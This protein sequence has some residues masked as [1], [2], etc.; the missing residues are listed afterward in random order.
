MN[1]ND[2]NSIKSKTGI[3]VSAMKKAADEGKLDEYVSKNLSADA[4]KKLKAVL[5]DKKATE[6]LLSSPQAKELMK[7]LKGDK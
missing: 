2:K 4:S 6:K 3:D 1:F 5:S 7:K